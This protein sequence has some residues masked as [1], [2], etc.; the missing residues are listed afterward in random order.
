M[1]VANYVELALKRRNLSSS[2]HLQVFIAIVHVQLTLS[3][4]YNNAENNAE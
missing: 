1:N 2:K 3:V 4:N